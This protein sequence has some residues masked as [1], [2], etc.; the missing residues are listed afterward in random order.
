[1]VRWYIGIDMEKTNTGLTIP[2]GLLNDLDDEILKLK[3]AKKL[4][5]ER[6]RSRIISAMVMDWLEVEDKEEWAEEHDLVPTQEDDSGNQT[7][8]AA[9]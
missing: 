6:V 9:D 8:I 3:A 4:P 5:D 2:T 7:L 1:M